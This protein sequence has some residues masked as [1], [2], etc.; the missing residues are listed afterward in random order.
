MV[1]TFGAETANLQLFCDDHDDVEVVSRDV[2]FS[3]EDEGHGQ[4]EE[5]GRRHGQDRD[6]RAVAGSTDKHAF[7]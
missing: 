5:V 4:L 7:K 1:V 2:R 3:L 6:L